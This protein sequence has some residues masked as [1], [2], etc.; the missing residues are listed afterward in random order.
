MGGA[1]GLVIAELYDATLTTA[2][3]ATTPRL[4]NVSILKQIDAGEVLT[5]GFVIGGTTAK[6]VLVRAIG[7]TLGVAPFNVGGAMADPKVSLFSGQTVI[8]A[9]DN[10]G[11]GPLLSAT[12]GAV[13]AFAVGNAA[14]RDAILVAT[15]APGSYTVQVSGANSTSGLTLVEVYEVP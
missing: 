10:W 8:A 3:T 11:G 14:S 13:G 9:N 15:L 1:T 2:F 6:Q 4:V 12:A 5:V 7:P